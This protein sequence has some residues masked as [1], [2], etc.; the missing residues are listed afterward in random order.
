[1]TETPGPDPQLI[2]AAEDW[3]R[4]DPDETDRAV[5]QA[6]IAASRDGDPVLS[7]IHI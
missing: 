1:M 3:L 6:E 4:Q 2:A 5:L 7:L